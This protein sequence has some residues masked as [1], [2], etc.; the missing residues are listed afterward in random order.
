MDMKAYSEMIHGIVVPANLSYEERAKRY[1][2]LMDFLR[3]ETP[4]E[5]YRFRCCDENS[6]SAFDQ[7]QI[8]FSPGYKMND[9]FD[10]LLYFDKEAIKSNL[11]T[12]LQ[13]ENII[14]AIQSIGQGAEIPAP[15]QNLFPSEMLETVRNGIIQMDQTAITTALDQFYSLCTNEIDINDTAIRQIIQS[16]KSIKFACFSKAIDSAAM[17]GYYAGSS[18]GFALSYDFRDG[19]YI[20][21]DSCLNGNQCPNYK[22]SS[23]AP[24][25]YDDNRFDATVYATR[26]VQQQITQKVLAERNA[27]ALYSLFQ[28]MMPCPDMFMG[29]KVLLHKA[30]AWSHEQEWRLTCQ[31]S[32]SKFKEEEFSYAEKRPTAVYLGRKISPIHE[33]ILRHIAVDKN[34]PVYKMRI[35]T[36]EL[37]YKLYPEKIS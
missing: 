17:W 36:E 11:K 37:S 7:D 28:D 18:S 30:S 13:S 34:I 24:V 23:L 27:F 25:V 19:H 5:L 6:I 4:R 9:D 20:K 33:K 2:P 16:Q 29:T 8:W 21:C 22:N 12:A 14:S 3:K 32:S 31:N 15:V 26:L 10:T 35:R 1:Q